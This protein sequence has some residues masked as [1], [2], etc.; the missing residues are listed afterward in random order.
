MPTLSESASEYTKHL[1]AKG[2][3]TT[4]AKGRHESLR[5][6]IKVVGDIDTARVSPQH[7]DKFFGA[8]SHWSAGTRNNRLSHLN[9][10]LDWCR[11]R[12]Y[13]PKVSDPTYG[14]NAI[15]YSVPE[16]LRIP[17][18]E[19]VRLFNACED[20]IETM[21]VATGLYGMLRGSEQQ[22]IQLKH[23][24]LNSVKPTMQVHRIKTKSWAV[25]PVVDELQTYLRQHLT[26]MA[27]QGFNDPNH[28]LLFSK[29]PAVNAQGG[30]FIAGSG[31]WNPDKPF[32]RPYDVIKAV[33]KRA[34]YPT[35][36]EGEHTLRRSGARALFESR[37]QE[38]YD[39]ALG[40]V[41]ALLGHAHASV[42]EDYIGVTL[43]ELR[44]HEELSG[45]PMYPVQDAN[46]VP[47]VRK[48]GNGE[49]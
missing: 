49:A 16:K 29:F 48:V 38:G 2:H 36:R 40:L 30:G 4:T 9:L 1:L 31:G 26:W 13:M 42:T 22:R 3:P 28:Y 15:K 47:M 39:G 8:N 14:W 18:S 35:Y 5:A 24:D 44:M 43:N 12:R 20:H 10:F 27:E 7:V 11:F 33:L 19:W 37:R 25:I 41:Q 6:F 46:I 23:I 32:Q 21:A 17:R 34:G 45:K